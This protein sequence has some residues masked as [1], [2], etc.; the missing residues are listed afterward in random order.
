M[1][2]YVHETG[3]PDAPAIVFLHG[4]GA[5]GWMW[6]QQ[7][8]AL[9]DFHCLAVDL[10]GHG[11]SNEIPWVSLK[12]TASQISD[13]I[14][15]RSAN[16]RA[17]VVGFSLG[18]YIALVLLD[19]YAQT[20]ERAII[21]GVTASPMPNRIFLRPQLWLTSVLWKQ[22]WFVKSIARSYNLSPDMEAD[23]TN[24][25]RLTSME[26]YK[27]ISREAVEFTV[28]ASLSS[29]DVPTLIVAGGDETKIIKDA[30][31]DIRQMMPKGQGYLATGLG[32][33]WNVQ[34][35]RLFNAMVRAW[36]TD[37]PLPHALQSVV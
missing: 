21:S 22:N 25:I 15:S 37:G 11:K 2:L 10:P 31:A 3:N 36:I 12:D 8:S 26:A 24:N 1:Q 34:N 27:A 32:H 28:P 16:G 17:H 20:V 6:K 13:I 33:G 7:V 29:V 30:V 9:S 18:G 4:I 23:L 19:N 35:P 5:S 14:Q